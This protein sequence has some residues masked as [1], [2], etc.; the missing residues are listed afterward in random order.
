MYPDDNGLLWVATEGKSG[1]KPSYTT[2]A[3]S[4]SGY[5]MLRNGWDKDATMMILKNNY[6]RPIN[7]IVSPIMELSVCIAKNVIS[8]RTQVYSPITQ[9]LPV[10][11]MLRL[12]TIIL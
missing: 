1:S 11:N 3:Y 6:I 9:E 8:S 7:G 4:T 10:A 5:Y 12:S 2:K